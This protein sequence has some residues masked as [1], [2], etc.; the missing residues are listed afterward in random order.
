M[1][2]TFI[3]ADIECNKPFHTDNP[4]KKYCDDRCQ[5]RTKHRKASQ[6][7]YSMAET[8]RPSKR[9]PKAGPRPHPPQDGKKTLHLQPLLCGPLTNER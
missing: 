9:G 5:S 6:K 2:Y 7:Y 8:M 1:T 4:K 3:C